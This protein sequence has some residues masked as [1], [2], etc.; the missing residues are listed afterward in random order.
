LAKRLLPELA[1]AMTEASWD[2]RAGGSGSFVWGLAP[3]RGSA[4]KRSGPNVLKTE[5]GMPG[6]HPGILILQV[7]QLFPTIGVGG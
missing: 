7:S 5:F 6:V 2:D 3:N 1:K 4:R